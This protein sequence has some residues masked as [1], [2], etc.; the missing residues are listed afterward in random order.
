MIPPSVLQVL[1]GYTEHTEATRK[2]LW[3]LRSNPEN[4]NHLPVEIH[5]AEISIMW[6]E[7]SII[8]QRAE[9]RKA[10]YLGEEVVAVKVLNGLLQLESSSEDNKRVS[11]QL[12]APGYK[13]RVW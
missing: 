9:I 11:G 4:N 3:K 8:G 12:A 7:R 1:Q 10:L 2:A 13:Y 5:K 6:K